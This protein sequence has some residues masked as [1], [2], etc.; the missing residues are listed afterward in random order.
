M[1][2]GIACLLLPTFA[3]LPFPHTVPR[4]EIPTM[5]AAFVLGEMNMGYTVLSER[6]RPP[7]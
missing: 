4:D 3:S 7:N 1:V 6:G 2:P 5:S